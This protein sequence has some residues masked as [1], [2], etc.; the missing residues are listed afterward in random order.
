MRLGDSNF[1]NLFARLAAAT[2]KN[3]DCDE[4]DVAGVHWIRQRHINWNATASFQIETHVL[5]QAGRKGW[6]LLYAHE[7]WWT[8]DR[9][10]AFRNASWVHLSSGNRADVLR[11]FS[12]RQDELDGR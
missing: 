11:W 7:T 6:T 8:E 12:E 4:W 9:K 1:L 5:R 2:N 10:R 3:R